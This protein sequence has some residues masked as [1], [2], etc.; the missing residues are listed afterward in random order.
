[1]DLP[2]VN[3]YQNCASFVYSTIAASYSL[4]S[5][6]ADG[7]VIARGSAGLPQAWKTLRM[8]HDRNQPG[9]DWGRT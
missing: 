7:S 6:P 8:A 4:H 3:C 5:L 2:R 1:M 9:V